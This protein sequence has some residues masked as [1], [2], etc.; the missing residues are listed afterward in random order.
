[1]GHVKISKLT[2]LA[3]IVFM[4]GCNQKPVRQAAPAMTDSVEVE[5]PRVEEKDSTLYGVAGDFGMST[6]CL[7]TDK[8]DTVLVTRDTE[9]G[10]DGIIYGDVQPGDRYSLITCDHGKALSSAINLTQLEHFTKNYKI[11]NGYLILTPS[12]K[13]DTV[14]I[15]FLNDDSL[16]VENSSKGLQK[17]TMKHKKV[18]SK[19]GNTMN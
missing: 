8:G 6:F 14:H 9:S 11:M 2:V 15:K 12:S 1:M 7:I 16:V 4:T 10:K 13:P 18:H 5:A 17:F 3:V 19:I